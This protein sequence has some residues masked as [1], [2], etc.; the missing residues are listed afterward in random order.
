MSD[1]SL[2]L[3]PVS[4]RRLQNRLNQQARRKRKAQERQS[5][6][7][8][9]RWVVY[10]D[11]IPSPAENEYQ[12]G[13]AA[14]TSPRLEDPPK[15]PNNENDYFCGSI[16]LPREVYWNQLQTKVANGAANNLLSSNLLLEVTQF[17][18]VRAMF[19]NAASMGLSLEVLCEDI[20]S[21]FN[22]AGPLTLQL[23]PSLQPSTTQKQ[24][25]HH[26]WI[27]LIP[28]ASLRNSL[29]LKLESLDEEELCTDLYGL[30]DSSPIVGLLV[31][32][33][34]WDPSAYEVTE[35]VARKWRW[36]LK[37]CPDLMKSTNY[38]RKQRGER[39]LR[40]ADFEDRRVEEVQ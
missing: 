7:Q 18:I 39:P 20:A 15:T 5:N 10:T 30:Y 14:T 29:L 11:K 36:I 26:P 40:L 22:I 38:W 1:P 16:N 32:G 12:Q 31:W 4:R 25:I 17:N 27:D 6:L 2:T 3:D 35:R 34:A 37:D 24:I 19:A 21:S 33:E 9:K 28:I 23:P 13:K 8:T